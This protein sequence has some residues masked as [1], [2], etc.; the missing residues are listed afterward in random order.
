MALTVDGGRG[1]SAVTMA[2][3]DA[4]TL[5]GYVLLAGGARPFT[6]TRA[7]LGSDRTQTRVSVTL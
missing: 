7:A 5:D 2:T 4:L 1:D 3:V 6:T